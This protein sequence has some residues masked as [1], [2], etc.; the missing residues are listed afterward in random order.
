MLSTDSL[1]KTFTGANMKRTLIVAAIAALFSTAA[2][3]QWGPGNQCDAD[4]P[5]MMGG[6]GHGAGMMGGYGHGPGMM[7]GHGHGYNRGGYEGLNLSTE[8][9]EKIA[10]IEKDAST[11]RFNTMKAMHDLR[12]STFGPNAT[13]EADPRQTYEAMATLRKQMFEANL[14]TQKRIEAVLTP[15]QKEQLTKSLRFRG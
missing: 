2:L 6:Y 13:K 3:A 4:G 11:A 12:W 14:D 15:E 9:R 1:A 5:G 7:G 8:Q 10:A